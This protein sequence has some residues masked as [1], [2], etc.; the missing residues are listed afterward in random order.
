MVLN[1][2]CAPEAKINKKIFYTTDG[3]FIDMAG[4][5]FG[6]TIA[7][8]T[9]DVAGDFSFLISQSGNKYGSSI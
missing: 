7:V 6:P 1:F 5:H 2:L 9:K 4:Q 3:I 8:P